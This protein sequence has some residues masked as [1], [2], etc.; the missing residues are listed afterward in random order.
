MKSGKWKLKSSDDHWPL[1]QRHRGS[2]GIYKYSSLGLAMG[3]FDEDAATQSR[4]RVMI[5]RG[6]RIWD[7]D[8]R[9]SVK[10]RSAQGLW[11][12]IANHGGY[13]SVG[14]RC[15]ICTFPSLRFHDPNVLAVRQQE[16]RL[17]PSPDS[18]LRKTPDVP[19]NASRRND[20]LQ[21]PSFSRF[22]S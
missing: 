4:S 13:V 16:P 19:R 2:R 15:D 7:V 8:I 20:C 11:T 12:V 5:G 14:R 9:M 6:T 1:V 3:L 17:G 18:A 10:D 22:G 21:P